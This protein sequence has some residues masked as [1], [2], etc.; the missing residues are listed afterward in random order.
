MINTPKIRFPWFSHQHDVEVEASAKPKLVPRFDNGNTRHAEDPMAD[1]RGQVLSIDEKTL[2]ADIVVNVSVTF[3]SGGYGTAQLLD[4]GNYWWQAGGA[5]GDQAA[6]PT[7][8]TEYVLSGFSGNAAYS[9]WFADTAYRAF[10]LTSLTGTG[11]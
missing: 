8:A 11:F 2:T 1:S 3:Y 5:G 7:Q 6:Y 9:I 10:R 4:N